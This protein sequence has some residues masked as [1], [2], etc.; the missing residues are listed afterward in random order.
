MSVVSPMG[1]AGGKYYMLSDIYDIILQ[2]D[3]DV[4]VDV[5]GGSG[6][7]LLNFPM[8]TLFGSYKGIYN[9]I[10]MRNIYFFNA[11][12]D[13]PNE[14]INGILNKNINNEYLKN[15]KKQK[16]YDALET[17]LDKAVA[18]WHMYFYAWSGFA[19]STFTWGVD[20][21][22]ITKRADY[23]TEQIMLAHD[24]VKNWDILNLDFDKL[25]FLDNERVF[26]Y[27]DPPYRL[28]DL[29]FF[30]FSDWD[31]LRLKRF[32]SRLKGQWLMNIDED[33]FIHYTF[34]EPQMRKTYRNLMMKHEN[35]SNREEWYYWKLSQ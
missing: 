11:I 18:T 19:S 3:F 4:I 30:N 22:D 2:Q 27:L 6:K 9:D 34:G 15:I 10:D 35:A 12:R 25:D 31:Y 28:S 7:V 26:W 23:V 1:Y 33:S 17:D 20:D 16:H 13:T 5:F 32:L 21:R 8:N 29:Y 24:R 14:L